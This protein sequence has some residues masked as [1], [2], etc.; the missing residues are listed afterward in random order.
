[1]HV[2]A[3]DRGGSV[4][5]GWGGYGQS[6]LVMIGAGSV[7]GL[8]VLVISVIFFQVKYLTSLV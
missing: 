1:M 4:I 3:F 2:L 8:Q 6:V 7:D 5:D